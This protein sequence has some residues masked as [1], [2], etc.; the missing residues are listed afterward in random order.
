MLISLVAATSL[1]GCCSSLRSDDPGCA[2]V[3]LEENGNY[4]VDY[5]WHY[6]ETRYGRDRHTAVPAYLEE[7]GLVPAPC[8]HG[9]VVLRGG[10]GEGGW[11]WAEFRCRGSEEPP[12]EEHQG[13]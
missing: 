4:S 12:R 9:V 5:K 1:S 2:Y 11:G 7:H 3:E 10:E 8:E 6:V 13:Q